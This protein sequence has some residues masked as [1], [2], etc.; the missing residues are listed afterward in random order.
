MDRSES[1]QHPE[2]STGSPGAGGNVVTRKALSFK[3]MGLGVQV[4][5][6]ACA[7]GKGRKRDAIPF[8][9]LSRAKCDVAILLRSL[10]IAES[11]TELGSQ[12]DIPGRG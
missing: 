6:E 8:S 9:N 11:A 2:A 3:E 10:T 12:V 1:F 4:V 7:K 5:V